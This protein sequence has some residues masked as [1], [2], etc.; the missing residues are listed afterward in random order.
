[1]IEYLDWWLNIK[2]LV[3]SK[4]GK[5]LHGTRNSDSKPISMDFRDQS[6]VVE[7]TPNS[8]EL[9]NSAGAAVIRVAAAAA[10]AAAGRTTRA[11][12]ISLA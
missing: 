11:R 10:A 6:C 2:A 7:K 8:M 3:L 5:F 4:L 1:M 9:R 12:K